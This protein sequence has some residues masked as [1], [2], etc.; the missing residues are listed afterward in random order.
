ML[1][2]PTGS[3]KH[4]DDCKNL[5]ELF[6]L[7]RVKFEALGV[8]KYYTI[9][10]TIYYQVDFNIRCYDWPRLRKSVD[11]VQLMTYEMMWGASRSRHHAPLYGSNRMGWQMCVDC[12]ARGYRQ[13]GMPNDFFVI[14]ITTYGRLF[15]N[16]MLEPFSQDPLNQMYYDQAF[17]EVGYNDALNWI[18]SGDKRWWDDESKAPYIYDAEQRAMLS[19]D[20]DESTRH[21]AQYVLDNNYGGLFFWDL[22]FDQ[23]TGDRS[24]IKAAYD[25]FKTNWRF[26]FD[27]YEVPCYDSPIYCNLDCSSP[28]PAILNRSEF[29]PFYDK[30]Q[31]PGLVSLVIA[32]GPNEYL[33]ATLKQILK[34]L[35]LTIVN[36]VGWNDIL[37]SRAASLAFGLKQDGHYVTHSGYNIT[38][39][40]VRMS[41]TQIQQQFK[42]ADALLGHVVGKRPITISA[43][44]GQYDDRI[45]NILG[46]MGHQLL[47]PSLDTRDWNFTG[48]DEAK[49][50]SILARVE[51]ILQTADGGS[52][53]NSWITQQSFY[54]KA[55]IEAIPDLVALYK[56]YGY[57]VVDMKTCL[58]PNAFAQYRD[59][60]PIDPAMR[61]PLPDFLTPYRKMCQLSGRVV[62]GFFASPGQKFEQILDYL[63]ETNRTAMFFIIGRQLGDSLYYPNLIRRAYREGHIIAHN[64]FS[65]LYYPNSSDAN[66]L[67]DLRRNDRELARIIGS[68]PRLVLP[69]Y[70]DLSFSA[71]RILSDNKYVA[72]ETR[73]FVSSES[74]FNGDEIRYYL[75]NY[76][77]S[78]SVSSYAALIQESEFSVGQV[79]KLVATLEEAGYKLESLAEC[80]NSSTY[81]STYEPVCGD[82]VCEVE[83]GESC[84]SCAKDCS[85]S[86][87]GIGP[88][89]GFFVAIDS[90]GAGTWWGLSAA[91]AIVMIGFGVTGVRMRASKHNQ[92]LKRSYADQ[93]EIQNVLGDFI[94]EQ[95]S[96]ISK[97][98]SLTLPSSERHVRKRSQKP[99]DG[100]AVSIKSPLKSPVPRDEP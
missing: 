36:I 71:S 34:D 58:G 30:C 33:A 1:G 75:R 96:G 11:F 52:A 76:F 94:K 79:N 12:I 31:R 10:N 57:Q 86:G 4:P 42:I 82:E 73:F 45:L 6:E 9:V 65:F 84:T 85:C 29:A 67:G 44:N 18:K 20:D 13:T 54:T 60:I 66:I 88:G 83:V 53:K 47:M 3:S 55:S 80:V 28:P 7:L 35:N 14:G 72:M 90:G 46:R 37:S 5:I 89:T 27:D 98:P 23:G 69:P 16:V 22:S 49:K 25:V 59:T 17:P 21:K 38:S 51:N 15:R 81:Y 39:S 32:G 8:D 97:T 61:V 70:G 62:L 100:F 91:G 87:I 19:Y 64:S 40:I 95:Q 99:P 74:K 41:E 48:T 43:P 26:S 24:M 78:A 93:K 68:R 56:R 92:L 2:G 63:T 50:Q 77:D